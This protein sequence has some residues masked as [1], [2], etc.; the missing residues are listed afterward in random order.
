MNR[1]KLKLEIW[2]SL[3]TLTTAPHWRKSKDSLRPM[4]AKLML[5]ISRMLL[6]SIKVFL[7]LA[8]SK[9]LSN[10]SSSMWKSMTTFQV[11]WL[12]N[13]THPLGPSKK[14]MENICKEMP[15]NSLFLNSY[16]KNF[17]MS[18]TKDRSSK[19]LLLI[20]CC[21]TL[22]FLMWSLGKF[23]KLVRNKKLVLLCSKLS[24]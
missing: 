7:L 4:L 2:I 1:R 9:L 20:F 23:V 19:K 12:L 24:I 18:P 16:T 17:S 11:T 21:T 3:S 6:L 8:I 14:I 10:I 22:A 5:I 15:S 13:L